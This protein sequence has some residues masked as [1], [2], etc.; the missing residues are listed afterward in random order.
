MISRQKAHAIRSMIEKAATSLDDKDASQAPELF[1]KMLYDGH[2]ISY[3]TRINWNGSLKIAAQD[4]WDREEFNP[5]NAPNLWDDIEYRDGIRIIPEIITV[6]KAFSMG[7]QGLW[8]N[9]VYE[10]LIN[11]N[12]YTPEQYPNGWK[13][14]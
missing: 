4:I 13:L 9:Q 6:A 11:A 7:E 5:D 3:G 10:S 14:I 8:K 12:V 2:L 1:E